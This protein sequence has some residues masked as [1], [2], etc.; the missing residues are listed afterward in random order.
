MAKPKKPRRH[1][2]LSDRVFI[3]QELVRG[4]SFTE[5]GKALGKDPSTIAKEVKLHYEVIKATYVVYTCRLCSYYSDC[6]LTLLCGRKHCGRKCKECYSF[7]RDHDCPYGDIK[8]CSVPLKPPYV[9]NACESRFSCHMEKHVYH[10]KRA[11]AEYE[12]TLVKSRVGINM[13]P[14]ELARLDEVIS[15]L[16]KKGQPLSHIFAVHAD[17]IPVCRRT[18]YNYLDQRVFEARNIDLHRRVR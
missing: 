8:K 10:A 1:L 7:N 9:C 5:I 13:T 12:E 3:E 15:P 6:K 4:S 2:T 16:I 14:E 18:L 17:D 11:Q